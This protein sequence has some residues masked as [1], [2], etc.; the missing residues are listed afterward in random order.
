[1]ILIEYSYKDFNYDAAMNGHLCIMVRSDYTPPE[2]REDN[3]ICNLDIQSDTKA[4]PNQFFGG[5]GICKEDNRGMVFVINSTTYIFDQSGKPLSD[6]TKNLGNN[7]NAYWLLYLAEII[8]EPQDQG[9]AV[10]NNVKVTNTRTATGIIVSYDYGQGSTVVVD[11]LNARDA[12]A[13][14]AL[15]GIMEK[16]NKP[17]AVSDNEMDFYTNKA[18]R[19]AAN[20]MMAAA[21][22]RA[23]YKDDTGSGVSADTLANNT[24]KL[25]FDIK[26]ALERTDVKDGNDYYERV[27]VKGWQDLLDALGDSGSSSAKSTVLY[28]YRNKAEAIED[29][30]TYD[31]ETSK[32][33]KENYD[34]VAGED[35]DTDAKKLPTYRYVQK[36]SMVEMA[37]LIK[38][39]DKLTAQVKR[40]AD[41]MTSSNS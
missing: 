27:S 34:D 3:I 6:N 8:K 7:G 21:Q 17:D 32:W 40:I 33:K 1:M 41:S 25:L 12:F 5:A 26:G 19:W 30:W 37:D 10:S 35:T 20:M 18:Y 36:Q 4:I 39:I 2:G 31:P 23:E 14:Q 15:Q 13:M 11:Q 29:G 38:S 28:A 24:E 16:I 22:A 9:S